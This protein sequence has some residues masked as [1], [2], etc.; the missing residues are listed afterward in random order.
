MSAWG[1]PAED[2]AISIELRVDVAADRE[3]YKATIDVAPVEIAVRA[4]RR[5]VLDAIRAAAE[6]CALRLCRRGYPVTAADVLG[7]LKM[8]DGTAAP[9]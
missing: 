9:N 3:S 4:T 7:S 2:L 8:V 5:D 1:G 6:R